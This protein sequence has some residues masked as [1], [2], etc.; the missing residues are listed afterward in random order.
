MQHYCINYSNENYR[1]MESIHWIISVHL[2]SSHNNLAFPA[3]TWNLASTKQNE[4]TRY[5][6]HNGFS[7]T[8]PPKEATSCLLLH[9]SQERS[10]TCWCKTFDAIGVCTTTSQVTSSSSAYWLLAFHLPSGSFLS[11][12][13]GHGKA[14]H[15]VY[16]HIQSN[17]EQQQKLLI[18]PIST[19]SNMFSPDLGCSAKQASWHCPAEA[20]W[21]NIKILGPFLLQKTHS[22]LW[23]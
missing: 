17:R 19:H 21:S 18:F 20:Y 13:C 16:L 3:E 6:I 14:V 15:L 12:Y 8:L 10:K 1:I 7:L 4:M 5:A 9:S 23:H 2:F 22:A 11:S